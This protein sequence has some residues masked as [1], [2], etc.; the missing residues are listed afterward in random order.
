MSVP[1]SNSHI[2]QIKAC[3]LSY[4]WLKINQ[5]MNNLSIPVSQASLLCCLLVKSLFCLNESLFF[6][7]NIVLQQEHCACKTAKACKTTKCYYWLHLW[8][9]HKTV[10]YYSLMYV[11][12]YLKLEGCVGLLEFWPIS[13]VPERILTNPSSCWRN[14]DQSSPLVKEFCPIFLAHEWILTNPALSWRNSDQ[15]HLLIEEFCPVQP[16]C[17]AI[18]S[19]PI[20]SWKNSDQSLP[21]LKEFWLISPAHE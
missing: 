8:T 13:P 12:F 14:S 9:N 6:F 11:D 2:S 17:K 4:T 18:P 15:T 21:L 16:T 20:F 1:H 10:I 7:L 19:N 3:H 5:Q